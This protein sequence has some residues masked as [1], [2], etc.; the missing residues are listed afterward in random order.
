MSS[1]TR[2]ELAQWAALGWVVCMD[3]D[4]SLDNL[5]AHECVSGVLNWYECMIRALMRSASSD[6]SDL[7]KTLRQSARDAA[8]TRYTYLTRPHRL[9]IAR[10]YAFLATIMEAASACRPLGKL[11]KYAG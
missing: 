3:Y 7:V 10:M 8:T 4:A 9:V 2:Y 6:F 11:A 5:Y 1:L